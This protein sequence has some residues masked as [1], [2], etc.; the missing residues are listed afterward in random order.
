MALVSRDLTDCQVPGF[1]AMSFRD[2]ETDWPV[3]GDEKFLQWHT[4]MSAGSTV[5]E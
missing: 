1:V 3:I 2:G 4:A 5:A